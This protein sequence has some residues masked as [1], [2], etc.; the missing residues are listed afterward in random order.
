MT[1][2]PPALR[3]APAAAGFGQGHRVVAPGILGWARVLLQDAIQS[4]KTQR[5]ARPSSDCSIYK[6][7]RMAV[8]DLCLIFSGHRSSPSH[9]SVLV[10]RRHKSA[11]SHFSKSARSCMLWRYEEALAMYNRAFIF[12]PTI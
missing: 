2:M 5:V 10:R 11:L 1:A 12:P 6:S 4:P 9:L 3:S 8:A 7:I